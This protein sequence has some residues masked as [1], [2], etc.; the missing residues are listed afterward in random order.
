MWFSSESSFLIFKLSVK[1]FNVVEIKNFE[2]LE[3][4]AK[5]REAQIPQV[6]DLL[7]EMKGQFS[8]FDEEA[9]SEET[10]QFQQLSS[11]HINMSLRSSAEASD[12]SSTKSRSEIEHVLVLPEDAARSGSDFEGQDVMEAAS[13]QIKKI[14]GVGHGIKQG[15]QIKPTN[16]KINL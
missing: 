7:E 5:T 4:D 12:H 3:E 15:A 11:V 16:S 1:S 9:N 14:L 13:P 8:K 10:A 2:E 6:E